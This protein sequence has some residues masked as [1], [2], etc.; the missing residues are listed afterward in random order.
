MY[1]PY[2]TFQ[3]LADNCSFLDE[4][5]EGAFFKNY[6]QQFEAFPGTELADLVARDGLYSHPEKA[7][8]DCEYR[9]ADPQ[10]ECFMKHVQSFSGTCGTLD[11]LLFKVEYSLPRYEMAQDS[12]ACRIVHRLNR[13]R[14]EIAIWNDK[15]VR[16]LLAQ[17]RDGVPPAVR[18][19][20]FAQ[21]VV[22]YADHCSELLEQFERNIPQ[23]AEYKA[24]VKE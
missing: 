18:E 9:M 22:R 10:V 14:R 19:A 7:Y 11:R 5:G 16:G 15:F 6:C 24:C 23:Y 3:N 21:V 12:E 4:T 1:Q 2:S 8:R 13:M 20:E 17:H